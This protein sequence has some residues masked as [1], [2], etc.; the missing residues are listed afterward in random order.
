MIAKSIKQQSGTSYIPFSPPGSSFDPRPPGLREVRG[1]P[2]PLRG[3][4][5]TSPML[6]TG[7]SQLAMRWP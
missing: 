6:F 1:V 5:G 4:S 7:G 2:E 3:R